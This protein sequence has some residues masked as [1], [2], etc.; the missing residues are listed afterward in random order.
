MKPLLFACTCLF[1][2][3]WSG[4]RPG[5][6]AKKE[7]ER[8]EKADKD[9][10]VR[11]ITDEDLGTDSPEP[12]DEAEDIETATPRKTESSVE[13]SVPSSRERMAGDP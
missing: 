11:V 10:P 9:G 12:E 3:R 13:V 6:L 5:Q 7:K 1:L 2:A 4:E 8:R